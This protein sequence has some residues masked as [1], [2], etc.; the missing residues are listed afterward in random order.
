MS[1]GRSFLVFRRDIWK[2]KKTQPSRIGK[3]ISKSELESII[4][5]AVSSISQFHHWVRRGKY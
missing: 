1:A 2:K 3:I 5:L 4:I